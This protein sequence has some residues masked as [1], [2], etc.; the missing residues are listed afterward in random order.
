MGINMGQQFPEISAETKAFIE[1]QKLFFVASADVDGRVNVSPKGA[2]SLRVLDGNRVVWMNLTGSG[3]E[4][5]AHIL[6]ANRITIMFCSFDEKP[7]ILRLYGT[8][9]VVHSFDAQWSEL[10]DLF[11]PSVGARQIFDVSVDMVQTSCGFQVPYFEYQGERDMLH[12]WS[13]KR[14]REGVEQYWKDRNLRSI[15]GKPT[16][17]EH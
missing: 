9:R 11:P 1:K 7:M 15:D 13:E 16:G 12:K 14:G 17:I 10:T 2:D 8:A 6:A 4:T 3:N 5:A